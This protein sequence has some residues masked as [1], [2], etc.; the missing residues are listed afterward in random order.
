MVG[1]ALP[2]GQEDRGL[3]AR[4]T[5]RR[6]RIHDVTLP[7]H[8]GMLTWPGDPSIDVLPSKR[9]VRGDSSNVSELRMG[10]HTGTHVDAPFH[11]IDG[12]PGVDGI[13]LASLVGPCEVVDMRDVEETIGPRECERIPD[14]TERVLFRTSNSSIWD[15]AAPAFPEAYVHLSVEG[16]RALVDRGV[17]LVGTDFLSIEQRGSEGHPT[18]VALLEAGVVIVE[19]LDLRGVEP[20]RYTIVCAPLKL[21]AGDGAPARVLLLDG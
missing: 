10:T 2:L 14:G 6:M 15:A 17:V 13:P 12:A 21:V 1:E 5:L 8:V 11:F 9:L 7:V 4:A 3:S 20:G 16:A 19:G 18:H